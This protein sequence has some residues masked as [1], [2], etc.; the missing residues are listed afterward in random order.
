MQKGSGRGYRGHSAPHFCVAKTSFHELSP[1]AA[2]TTASVSFAST[3]MPGIQHR[4]SKK[5]QRGQKDGLAGNRTLDH[6]HAVSLR[7]LNNPRNLMLR[8]YYTTK[9]QAQ[10]EFLILDF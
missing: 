2:Y 9:P 6:S 5:K 4:K 7:S 3:L 10:C 1:A 8:E